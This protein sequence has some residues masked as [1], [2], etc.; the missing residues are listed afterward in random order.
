MTRF[1]R[2]NHAIMQTMKLPERLFEK[3]YFILFA[4]LCLEELAVL[5]TPHSE[6][7]VYYHILGAFHPPARIFYYLA[8]M[9]T[10]ITIICLPPLFNYAF[11]KKRD[12]AWFFKPLLFVRIVLDVTGHN[13]EFQFLKILSHTS[14]F[15]P[16][17]AISI[18]IGITFLSY[19]AHF[20]CAFPE[21]KTGAH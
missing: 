15:L 9:R 13:H 2:I 14:T 19:K 4:W 6:A 11:N 1:V 10:G 21:N 8:I 5:W 18:W 17:A 12:W 20:L 7:F 3:S 16:L